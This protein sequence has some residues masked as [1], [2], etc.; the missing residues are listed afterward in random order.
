MKRLTLFDSINL[1]SSSAYKDPAAIA[2]LQIVFGDLSESAIPCHP[3]NAAYTVF[4]ASDRPMQSITAVYED[5][6]KITSGF[7][8]MPAYQDETG[9]SIACVIFDHAKP[10]QKISIAGKGCMNDAGELIENP[11]DLI[12]YLF[13][14]I[15]GY[16][17]ASIDSAELARF[18]AD[19]L[20]EEIK[21]AC[22]ISDTGKLRSFLDELA[23][24]IH[25]RWMLSDGKSVMRLRWI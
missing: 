4:H 18:Y 2:P 21:T 25:A 1:R 23:Q 12:E 17:P 24:N 11:A 14:H 10:T 8:A 19:C 20:K 3:I 13:L 7:K 9:Q 5:G 16:D 6:G 15:Q 22:L